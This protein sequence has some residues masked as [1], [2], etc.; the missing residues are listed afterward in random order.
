MQTKA[1]V[2]CL[3]ICSVIFVVLSVVELIN[4]MVLL[5]TELTIDG[6][7]ILLS[8]I[9]FSSENFPLEGT[10]LWIFFTI[11]VCCFLVIG[12]LFRLMSIKKDFEPKLL[13]KYLVGLGILILVFSFVKLEYISLLAKTPILLVEDSD[14]TLQAA[15]YNPHVA[16]FSA[17]VLWIFFTAVICGS[18]IV[19]IVVTAGGLKWLIEMEEQ[20]KK[21][22]EKKEEK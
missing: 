17:A 22:S 3:K 2:K 20:E 5:N 21:E 19:G 9:I 8:K 6:K 18:L 1:V 12:I 10:L 7:E 15:L 14:F 4:I 11:F 16:P 13:A